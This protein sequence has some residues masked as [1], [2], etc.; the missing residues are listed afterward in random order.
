MKMLS[1][2]E[3]DKD[4][5]YK[6]I[7]EDGYALAK[8]YQKVFAGVKGEKV[9]EDLMEKFCHDAAFVPGASVNDACYFE[10]QRSVMNYINYQMKYKA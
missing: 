7:R 2:Y 5:I 10:G 8:E 6:K 1:D 9:F 4:E 3:Q